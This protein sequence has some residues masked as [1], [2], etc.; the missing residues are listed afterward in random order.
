[1]SKIDA[2]NFTGSTRKL[3]VVLANTGTPD[4]PDP[5]AVGAYLE[6]FLQDPRI[7]PAMPSA[8]WRRIVTRHIVP[9]RSTRSAAKYWTIW[10]GSDFPLR[11]L[12]ANLAQKLESHLC[13]SGIQAAVRPGMS[14]GA[15]SLEDACEALRA[16]GCTHIHVLPLY[17]QTAFS[18]TGAVQD[19]ALRAQDTLGFPHVEVGGSY[20]EDA[21]Y[22]QALASAIRQAGFDAQAGDMLFFGFHSIPLTDIRHG[23][24][25]EA[26]VRSTCAL[27]ARALQLNDAAWTL[28]FQCRFDKARKWLTPFAKEEL[29]NLA[30]RG[31]RGRLFY[32]CPNF[33]IDCLETLY[34][35]PHELAP[36]YLGPNN[37]PRD[38]FVYVPCLN[39]SDAHVQVLAN[40]LGAPA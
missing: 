27:V 23:D 35:V 36:L 32:V 17:P 21:L 15:P 33:A 3:G 2:A 39:D 13:S 9:V 26:Q 25:Y 34:D 8:L 19:A 31:L 18:T 37:L 28:G 14:Y 22:I 6:A 10:D 29:A 24:T 1:M 20:A 4:S 11:T 16:E 38:R 40:V 7:A 12:T 30:A 5:A